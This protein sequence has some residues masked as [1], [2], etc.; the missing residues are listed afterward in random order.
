[1]LS[2]DIMAITTLRRARRNKNLYY[3]DINISNFIFIYKR[4]FFR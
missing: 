1:M 3:S 2:T 4:I